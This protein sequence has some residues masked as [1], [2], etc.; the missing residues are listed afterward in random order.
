LQ[1][2]KQD[3][4]EVLGYSRWGFQTRQESIRT[5]TSGM[6][7]MN[8][9]HWV[10]LVVGAMVLLIVVGALFGP[11]TTALAGYAANDTS[12]L[13][14]ILQTLVPILIGVGILLGFIGAF[15]HFK[16]K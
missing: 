1:I 14:A 10:S 7:Q 9:G 16:G 8:V 5:N 2:L 11:L 4:I 15:L 12:G 13:G 3:K 6:A